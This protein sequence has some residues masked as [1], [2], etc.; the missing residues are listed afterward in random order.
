MTDATLRPYVRIITLSLSGRTDSAAVRAAVLRPG[1]TCSAV[2]PAGRCELGNRRQGVKLTTEVVA[3]VSGEYV[4]R[5]WDAW[6]VW[7]GHYEERHAHPRQPV[8][9][10]GLHHRVQGGAG[11]AGRA[12][13]TGRAAQ[14]QGGAGYGRRAG[15]ARS[16]AGIRAA[17]HGPAPRGGLLVRLRRRE[18]MNGPPRMS[19][20]MVTMA[21]GPRAAFGDEP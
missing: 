2:G 12:G 18:R 11:G 6:H 16:A 15:A 9:R 21:T 20:P 10:H 17:R 5:P 3:A 13:A 1:D 19:Y 14:D 7:G 4:V 8:G